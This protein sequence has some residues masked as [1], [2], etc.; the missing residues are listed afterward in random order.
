MQKLSQLALSILSIVAALALV[1]CGSTFTFIKKPQASPL[2]GAKKI[3][4]APVTYDGLNI[5]DKPYAKYIEEKK[6]E[7]AEEGAKGEESEAAN[8]EE[9]RARWSK[10]TAGYIA[11]QLKD[12]GI[13]AAQAEAPAEGLVVK[14]NVEFIEPGFYAV[15]AS[16]PSQTR[17]RVKI[18]DTAKPDAPMYDFHGTMS[19]SGPN[20]DY[21]VSNDLETLGGRIAGFL[22]EEMTAAE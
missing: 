13:E 7:D 3:T 17:I 1:S 5:G 11:Q 22:T 14:T 20:V 2:K 12:A 6:A 21:R 4:V 15:V 9:M 16:M 10:D 18:F 19:H 8:W